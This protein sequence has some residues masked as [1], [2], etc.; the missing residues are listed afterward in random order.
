MNFKLKFPSF[1]QYLS[2]L[3]S[4]DRY[5]F[6][7]ISK[8]SKHGS[9]K[10]TIQTQNMQ[11]IRNKTKQIITLYRLDNC[12]FQNRSLSFTTKITQFIFFLFFIKIIYHVPNNRKYDMKIT[13][14]RK[15]FSMKNNFS[16][17]LF[18]TQSNGTQ[19]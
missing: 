7:L 10:S 17:K 1:E 13:F 9:R 2:L 16:R 4:F 6:F 15:I 8:A 18:S 5:L 11:P 14:S 3:R 12:A 19:I